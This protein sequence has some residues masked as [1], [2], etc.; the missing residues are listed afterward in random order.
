VIA[1]R[2]HELLSG[3]STDFQILRGGSYKVRA[4]SFRWACEGYL[5]QQLYEPSCGYS[6]VRASVE[7]ARV[8]P[9][10]HDAE[11][12]R[13]KQ[14]SSVVFG[15]SLCLLLETLETLVPSKWLFFAWCCPVALCRHEFERKIA[16]VE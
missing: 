3:R 8:V 11:L 5:S 13:R 15:Q 2:Y 10:T 12:G 1:A 14:H 16:G 4:G 7:K 6:M 9:I